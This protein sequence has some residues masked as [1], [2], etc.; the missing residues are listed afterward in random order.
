MLR[1]SHTPSFFEPNRFYAIDPLK[2]G[3][4]D[5]RAHA[6]PTQEKEKRRKTYERAVEFFSKAL[7]LDPR[8]AYAA[9]GVAI[10]M[11]EDKKDFNGAIQIFLKVKET[12]KESCVLINLG[13][14]YGEMKQFQ[15]AI[16]QV[17]CI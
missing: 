7:Q 8:N 6:R 16:E 11:A 15:R 3:A 14:A 9:Q 17:S 4:L 13:H 5:A 1:S 10:A 2:S 12:V